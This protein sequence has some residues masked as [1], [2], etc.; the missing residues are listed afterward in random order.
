MPKRFKVYAALLA[1]LALGAGYLSVRV[2]QPF[3]AAGPALQAGVARA[4][5]QALAAH[6]RM[7]AETLPRRDWRRPEHMA[8]T[9]AYIEEQLRRAQGARVERQV[10]GLEGTQHVNV[11]ASFGPE[12]GER[13]VVG[14]HYDAAEGLPGADDNASGV[15][16]LLELAR[17]LAA[18]PPPLRV[19]LVAYALEEPPHFRTEGMGSRR[20]ARALTAAGVKVRAMVVLE[21]IGTFDDTEGSQR[22]PMAAL[23]AVYPSRG[24]FIAVVGRLGADDALVA[25]VK[26]ALRCAPGLKVESINALPS[27]PGVDFSD[28]A[29]YWQEG[30]TAAM[31]TDT[32]FYRNPRYHT[33]LDTWDTLDYARMALVV[34]GVACWVRGAAR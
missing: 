34:D 26:A 22:F 10:F 5:P 2:S 3:V 32:A 13:V 14:A 11:V 19:D 25:Q 9:V 4:D 23:K 7:L 21:M 12:D 33:R 29:S 27:L 1:I 6:V 18:T 20:H 17:L 31:V 24:D 15:A 30:I 8:Q 16:G 28:H